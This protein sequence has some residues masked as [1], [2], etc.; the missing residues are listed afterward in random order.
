[1]LARR[2]DYAAPRAGINVNVRINAALADQLESVQTLDQRRADR[3]ALADQHERF[4]V[5][6]PLR[7]R[8]DVL[9]VV[10]PDCHIV[11]GEL[12]EARQCPDRVVVI[13]EYRDVH[14]NVSAVQTSDSNPSSRSSGP[15]PALRL[16]SAA[17]G[18][19]RSS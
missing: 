4:G 8:I 15:A 17:R 10:I 19:R 12:A 5:L 3:R 1:M 11:P 7:E 6:K 14:L 9:G 2:N 16:R 13:V 18:R